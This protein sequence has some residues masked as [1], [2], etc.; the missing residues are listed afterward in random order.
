VLPSG[1]LLE[2]TEEEPELLQIARSSYGL[3]GIIYEVTFRV[4][5]I[6]PMAVHHV[7]YGID[8]FK[9]QLPSLIKQDISM[10]LYM[11]PF[12]N[13]VTVEYRKYYESTE[14]EPN[15]M[16]WA[17]RNWVWGKFAP[18]VS[19]YLTTYVPN[20]DLR[21]F[22][23][24][25]FNRIIQLALQIVVNSPYTIATDQ[26][27]RYGE[28]SGKSRYTFSIWA[29]PE[30]EYPDH[31][32]A[33]FRFCQDYYEQTGFRCDM[34]NVGY[35]IEKDQSSLFSYSYNGNVLTL[36][37]VATGREKGWDDFLKAY[38]QFCSDRGG[39]PLFNQT[40]WITQPQSRK[41]FGERIGKFNS[42]R[43]KYDPDNRLLNDYFKEMFT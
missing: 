14:G 42:F 29:F 4:R 8:D 28:T 7:T 10:M 37:P 19:Y 22:L 26:M 2:V 23:V 27:I 11:Y 15:R 3:M 30:D 31:I 13:Q 17:I 41:A 35:R 39:V 43:E 12:L 18:T 21:Y 20:K 5:P 24:N 33:Y 34:L 6:K 32:A 16:A 1:E 40:K 38:N 25:N 36:D 9:A